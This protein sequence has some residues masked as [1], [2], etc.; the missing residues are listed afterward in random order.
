MKRTYPAI[1]QSLFIEVTSLVERQ[2]TLHKESL[3]LCAKQEELL[4]DFNKLLSKAKERERKRLWN[5]QARKAYVKCNATKTDHLLT[6]DN[7]PANQSKVKD[8][9][10]PQERIK[11]P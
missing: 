3:L 6:K 5:Q 1:L 4:K 9:L 10:A 7:H 11:K 8:V 2:E